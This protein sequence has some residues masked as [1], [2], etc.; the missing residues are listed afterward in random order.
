[1]PTKAQGCYCDPTPL[2]PECGWGCSACLVNGDQIADC[3]S[4]CAAEE[5]AFNCGFC[6]QYVPTSWSD[7]DGNP[8]VLAQACSAGAA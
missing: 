2:F 6:A 5:T 7:V 3:M 4:T 1:M 8:T